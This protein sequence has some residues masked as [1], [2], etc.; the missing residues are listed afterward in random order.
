MNLVILAL[1]GVATAGGLWALR[2]SRRL[3]T[4]TA[5]LLVLGAAGFAW[6]SAGHEP[7]RPV[8]ADVTPIAVDP[9]L[10]AF[11]EAV[12]SPSRDDSLALASADARLQAGDA[13]AA[14]DGLHSALALRPRDAALWAGLGYV[15]SLHDG[16]VSPAAKFAFARAVRLAPGTPGPPF[17]L[18]LAFF[19]MGDVA[20]ARPAWAYAL[21]TT[22]GDAP[23]R[24][25]IA[26]HVAAADQFLR[27][28]AAQRA[29]GIGP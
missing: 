25:D 3:W 2:V 14:A 16:A 20:G 24:R 18:G 12:F 13:H 10:V 7:G 1:V 26:Q 28:A 8:Q 9:G 11:R 5:A 23:Y 21:A 15:L 6:Q 27:I 22:P 19:N 29:A 17:F 4:L